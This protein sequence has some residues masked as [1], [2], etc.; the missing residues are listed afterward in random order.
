MKKGII[1][2]FAITCGLS[3]AF[4]QGNVGIG[5]NTPDASALLEMNS[6]TQGVLV[7]RL[8]TA[9]RLAV[10]S[11]ANGLLVFD[12]DVSC[13]FFYSSGLPGWEN[14]CSAGLSGISCWDVN[15][16]SVNDPAEDVNGDGFFNS[17][18]CQGPVGPQGPIGLTGPQGV[19]GP[20]GLT[21]PQGLQGDPGPTGLAGL[22]G[23]QGD[24][25]PQGPA[26]P[27]GVPGAT[28][29]AG[30]QGPQGPQGNP[31]PQGPVGPQG[32][33]GISGSFAKWVVTG[34]TD[35]SINSNAWGT[36]LT[37][38]FTPSTNIVYVFFSAAGHSVP[39]T[40][41]LVYVDF[42]C[43]VNG[44]P[45]RGTTTL[46]SNNTGTNAVTSY[47]ASLIL[48]ITVNPNILNTVTIQWRRD[49]TNPNTVFSN[50]V[51]TA[52]WSH[53]TLLITE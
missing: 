42:R 22:P 38:T 19:P 18:D 7:P 39:A 43:L 53:R 1:F 50:V 51:S 2:C 46:S 49:G 40:A 20:I 27:Q 41:S 29:A 12:T 3:I 6:N 11:P 31:G 23:P 10:L 15:G 34:T 35:L 24:P 45:T 26:G 28:G 25:G 8:T 48:P 47:S 30:P 44:V 14:L 32:P 36:F 5:T 33:Q 21:G 13:F 4:G 16:N 37:L 9:Q 17:L 52:D